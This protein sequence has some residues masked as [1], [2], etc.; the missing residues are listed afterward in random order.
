M[1][2]A[3][4]FGLSEHLA[5]LSKDGDPLEVLE[6]T[7]DFEDFRAWLVAGLGYGDGSKGGSPP[8]DPVSMFKACPGHQSGIVDASL[9]PALKQRN[10]GDEKAAIKTGQP[11]GEFWPDQPNKAAQKD[12]AAR[13]RG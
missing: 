8:F 12:T 7:L 4:L 5:R 6:A 3:G 11:T 9:V 13:P 2:Q 10:T 1:R